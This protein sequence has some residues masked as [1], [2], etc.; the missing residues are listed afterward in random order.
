MQRSLFISY[1]KF[2]YLYESGSRLFLFDFFFFF[3]NFFNFFSK[4]NF[5]CQ[6]FDVSRIF[7]SF[8]THRIFQGSI[9]FFGEMEIIQ[10]AT[11]ILRYDKKK[12]FQNNI[13]LFIN[14]KGLLYFHFEKYNEFYIN[15][16]YKLYYYKF[17]QSTHLRKCCLM[18]MFTQS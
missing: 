16:E 4:K 6:N 5:T 11:P 12:F 1:R 8:P 7:G 9:F 10:G 15:F 14:S 2:W 17:I 13:N 18:C 3:Q